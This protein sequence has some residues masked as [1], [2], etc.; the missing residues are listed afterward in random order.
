[1]KKVLAYLFALVLSISAINVFLPVHSFADSDTKR[2]TT[3]LSE[4][5]CDEDSDGSNIIELIKKAVGILTAG[6]VVAGTIGIIWC[7]FL[8]LTSRDNEAQ[9]AKARKRLI[10]VVIGIVLFVLGN[11]I[12]NLLFPGGDT[13]LLGG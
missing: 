7:G 8:I 4:S 10:D 3:L 12:I 2:C 11:V 5:W 9:V 6:V 13:S 1:M